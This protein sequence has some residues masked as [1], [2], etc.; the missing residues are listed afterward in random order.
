VTAAGIL[1]GAVAM[2]VVALIISRASSSR[3]TG[4]VEVDETYQALD[5][6]AIADIPDNTEI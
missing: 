1:L 4:V 3:Q 2:A 6:E 5:E